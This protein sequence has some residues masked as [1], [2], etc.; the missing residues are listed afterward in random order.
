MKRALFA[1]FV[2]TLVAVAFVAGGYA[3]VPSPISSPASSR[4]PTPAV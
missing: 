1:L 3:A 2:L 4:L